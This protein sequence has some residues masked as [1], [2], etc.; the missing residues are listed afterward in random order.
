MAFSIPPAVSATLGVGFP[1][2]GTLATPLVT[3]APR[4]FKSTNSLYSI[5]EPKVPEAVITG[6]F[7]STPARFTLVFIITPPPY[8]EIPVRLCRHVYYAPGNVHQFQK[9]GR[10]MQGRLRFRRPY[11]LPWK[12]SRGFLFPEHTP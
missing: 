8:T 6:F 7:S 10:R 12:S 4:R 3:T 1:G 5:P 11:A 9:T 2:Q